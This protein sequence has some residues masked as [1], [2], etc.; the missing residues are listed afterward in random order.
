MAVL[1]RLVIPLQENGTKTE[2]VV[3]T[4]VEWTVNEDALI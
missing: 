4:A 1:Y 2:A 3:E